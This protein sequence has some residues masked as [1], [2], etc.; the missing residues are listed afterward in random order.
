MAS[1]SLNVHSLLYAN[2]KPDFGANDVV[3]SNVDTSISTPT[4]TDN[5]LEITDGDEQ[6][7]AKSTSSRVSTGSAIAICDDHLAKTDPNSTPVITHVLLDGSQTTMSGSDHC[8]VSS[9]ANSN[10]QSTTHHS[11]ST[12]ADSAKISYPGSVVTTTVMESDEGSFEIGEVALCRQVGEPWWPGVV[13]GVSRANDEEEFRRLD[14]RRRQGSNGLSSKH[15][16]EYLEVSECGRDIAEGSSEDSDKTFRVQV[17]WILPNL[18]RCVGTLVPKSR[19]VKWTDSR[20]FLSKSMGKMHSILKLPRRCAIENAERLRAGLISLP[21]HIQRVINEEEPFKI[22]LYGVTNVIIESLNNADTEP[23]SPSLSATTDNTTG[24]FS[25]GRKSTAGLNNGTCTTS[26]GKIAFHSGRSA[27]LNGCSEGGGSCNGSAGVRRTRPPRVRVSS[28]TLVV[29]G[30]HVDNLLG[31]SSCGTVNTSAAMMTRRRNLLAGSKSNGCT[32]VMNAN[33][34]R[35]PLLSCVEG[36]EN[37]ERE[38]S[39]LRRLSES[40]RVFRAYIPD[41]MF[42]ENALFSSEDSPAVYNRDDS[43]NSVMSNYSS[44]GFDSQCCSMSAGTSV[45]S[46]RRTSDCSV[47]EVV[48]KLKEDD[49]SLSHLLEEEFANYA[50]SNSTNDSTA[51]VGTAVQSDSQ[52][53]RLTTI[54]RSNE[55]INTNL[56]S[57]IS[58]C[59]ANVVDK[60]CKATTAAASKASEMTRQTDSTNNQVAL[61]QSNINNIYTEDFKNARKRRPITWAPAQVRCLSC[62]RYR[63]WYD[64][65]ID[66]DSYYASVNPKC[67]SEC[68]TEL[69]GSIHRMMP[70]RSACPREECATDRRVARRRVGASV[71]DSILNHIPNY[72]TGAALANG[73][74]VGASSTEHTAVKRR[75]HSG[76]IHTGTAGNI[77]AD[78]QGCKNDSMLPVQSFIQSLANTVYSGDC[79]EVEPTLTVKKE[80]LDKFQYLRGLPD[81]LSVSV[82]LA[83]RYAEQRCVS[84]SVVTRNKLLNECVLPMEILPMDTMQPAG[85]TSSKDAIF[86]KQ[87]HGDCSTTAGTIAELRSHNLSPEI[88]LS[89][90]MPPQQQTQDDWAR[91]SSQ[92]DEELL[93]RQYGYKDNKSLYMDNNHNPAAVYSTAYDETVV[94]AINHGSKG[95]NKLWE[96]LEIPPKFA[97]DHTSDALYDSNHND[98]DARS[99]NMDC[100]G[101]VSI[102]VAAGAS[103]VKEESSSPSDVKADVSSHAVVQDDDPL[104]VMPPW[105]TDFILEPKIRSLSRKCNYTKSSSNNGYINACVNSKS[106]VANDSRVG[107]QHDLYDTDHLLSSGSSTAAAVNRS[108]QRIML[109]PPSST[110]G[111]PARSSRRLSN[112]CSE[113]Q[114]P[115]AS[116]NGDVAQSSSAAESTLASRTY[117]NFKV[118]STSNWSFLDCTWSNVSKLLGESWMLDE[119]RKAVSAGCF[120]WARGAD[121]VT[122][123]VDLAG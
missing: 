84:D 86:A 24:T 79:V 2:L 38:R 91:R 81:P 113:P 39:T 48:V 17:L 122:S 37:D 78:T 57:R 114:S 80:D 4:N 49:V 112:H 33:E 118:T 76:G 75:R 35:G 87:L 44:C 16:P 6:R 3:L 19:V 47:G 104:L 31:G 116:L 119:R 8:S 121:N 67:C 107:Q 82:F 29:N 21:D 65:D 117:P 110:G 62:S 13:C 64:L 14:Q 95:W 60:V 23:N 96:P 94:P 93:R 53:Q 40:H 120:S 100:T 71:S 22:Q 30:M 41:L 52:H 15:D 36:F 32:P 115:S 106:F 27:K 45:R 105:A 9:G 92:G 66:P 103:S 98:I 26:T 12:S 123:L 72:S 10:D 5:S 83:R 108:Q 18:D 46:S 28:S 11:G 7:V 69:D 54:D 43:F 68:N 58:N 56:G 50:T 102:G 73:L 51:A 90:R 1:E 59:S 63:S 42:W 34:L 88:M 70:Y 55:D 101:A 74:P 109:L 77:K 85:T 111:A 99:N 25:D 89:P 20:E 97:N 61:P